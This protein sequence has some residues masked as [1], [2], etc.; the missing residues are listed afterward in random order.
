MIVERA[1][2]RSES[3]LQD[4]IRR[5]AIGTSVVLHVATVGTVVAVVAVPL[6]IV[7]RP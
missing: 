6:Q 4:R 7:D 3:R 5:V 2:D 1:V